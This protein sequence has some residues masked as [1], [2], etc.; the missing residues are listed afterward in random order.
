MEPFRRVFN[1]DSLARE[2]DHAFALSSGDNSDHVALGAGGRQLQQQ[3][4]QQ[5]ACT[6]AHFDGGPEMVRAQLRPRHRNII[7]EEEE[8]EA[9]RAEHWQHALNKEN[10]HSLG[11]PHRATISANGAQQQRSYRQQ[12][13][14]D[15][16]TLHRPM[17]SLHQFGVISDDKGE[18]RQQRP[19]A[20]VEREGNEDFVSGVSAAATAAAAALTMAR[21]ESDL[22]PV[23]LMNKRQLVRA[24]NVTF[25]GDAKQNLVERLHEFTDCAYTNHERRE[26]I[27]SLLAGIKFLMNK[28]V[29]LIYRLVSGARGHE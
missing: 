24:L 9:A 7:E 18:P 3:Q 20:R 15:H 8:E 21:K 17:G 27:V 2:L 13:R 25:L 10:I 1:Q 29:K 14:R 6:R 12:R 26:R 16:V 22:C 19:R 11:D 23:V 5:S 4:Q 28:F